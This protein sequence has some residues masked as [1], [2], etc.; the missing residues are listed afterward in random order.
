MSNGFFATQKRLLYMINN[1][2]SFSQHIH[3]D[4]SLFVRDA[5]SGLG[6]SDSQLN[7]FDSHSTISI[8]LTDGE[9]INISLINDRLIVWSVIPLSTEQLFSDARAILSTLTT[10]FDSVETGS[11]SLGMCEG[12]FELKALVNIDAL[13]EKKLG[14][15]LS[16]FNSVS[17]SIYQPVM[18]PTR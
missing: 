3:Q 13:K 10:P 11:L 14:K 6:V 9:P 12:G 8:D 1:P 5:L 15:V 4:L 7:D 16:D 18:T 2:L 17:S